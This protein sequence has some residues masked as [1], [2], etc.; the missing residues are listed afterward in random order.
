MSRRVTAFRR[1]AFLLVI[2]TAVAVTFSLPCAS[3]DA[4][5]ATGTFAASKSAIGKKCKPAK[6]RASAKRGAATKPAKC[7]PRKGPVFRK[8]RPP[9]P[10]P[11]VLAPAPPVAQLPVA[12]GTPSPLPQTG[13]PAAPGS[14][15]EAP[16]P[17][18]SGRAV[19]VTG[20]EW[21]LGL[22]RQEVLGGDVTVEYNLF[23]AEDPHSLVLLRVDGTG[24]VYRFEEQASQTV[25]TKSLRFTPGRWL[26]LCDLT[27]HEAK[28]MRTELTVR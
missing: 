18:G 1:G 4:V 14:S 11:P 10:R 17:T 6:R 16:L 12:P 24:P 8:R 20:T 2:L 15:P 27:G 22:S 26:L 7:K 23:G 5:A 9:A 13:G 28:G 25:E 21:A 3:G 19:K